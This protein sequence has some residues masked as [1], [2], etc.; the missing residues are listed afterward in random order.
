[1]PG[2][3]AGSSYAACGLIPVFVAAPSGTGIFAGAVFPWHSGKIGGMEFNIATAG[4]TTANQV[5]VLVNGV[6]IFAQTA[7]RPTGQVGV[8]G[9][10]TQAS[11]IIKALKYGDVITVVGVTNGTSAANLTGAIALEKA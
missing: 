4:T 2:T 9:R 5:N 6:S 10:M 11:P 1:M 3:P 8:S 7:D